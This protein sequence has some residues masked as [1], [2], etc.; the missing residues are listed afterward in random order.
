MAIMMIFE[1]TNSYQIIL[2]LMF[3]C[4]ISHTTVRLLK[5][6]SFDEESLR[7]RGVTL[8]RGPEAGVMQTLRVADIMHTEVEAVPRAA[9]FTAIVAAFLKSQRNW[10]Y[11]VDNDGRFLGAISLH[12]IKDMLHQADSLGAV[13]AA[14]LVD[15]KFNFVT[16]GSSLADVLDKFWEQN[17]E[18]LPVLDGATHRKL[19]GWMSKRD[20]LG[21]Y[22][23]EILKKRQRLGHFV[24]HEGDEQRDVFVEL[25]ENFELRTVEV[26]GNYAGKTLAQLAPR[27]GYGV[28]V[29]A[30]KRHNDLT[31][32]D[33]VELP[34]PQTLLTAGDRLIVIGQFEGIAAFIA[35]LAT[36]LPSTES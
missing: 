19:I 23:Q 26:P 32:R 14:D 31:G 4:I 22:S 18:R 15:D 3:V 30:L 12:G 1:Q 13:C 25:P 8:P 27:S 35:A 28:H 7:R 24:T 16:P 17:S 11:V 9:P 34:G 21:V 6:H 10:L 29:I 36:D 33:T 2:P 20:L 5:G